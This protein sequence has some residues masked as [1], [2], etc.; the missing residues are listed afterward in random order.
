MGR[1][2]EVLANSPV[3]RF[4]IRPKDPQ[5]ANALLESVTRISMRLG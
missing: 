2:V 1:P 5:L 4:V 3:K